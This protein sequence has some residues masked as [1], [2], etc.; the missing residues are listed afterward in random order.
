M[1]KEQNRPFHI[2]QNDSLQILY[3]SESL[4]TMK[5]ACN[6]ITANNTIV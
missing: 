5:M 1:T 4:N 2:S 6:V 3:T